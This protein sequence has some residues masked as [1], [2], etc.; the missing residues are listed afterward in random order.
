MSRLCR[1]LIHKAVSHSL[2]II[3]PNRL[4]VIHPAWT[5][6]DAFENGILNWYPIYQLY[7][8]SIY[9]KYGW[10]VVSCFLLVTEP[11][12]GLQFVRAHLRHVK[13]TPW[14][15]SQWPSSSA[16]WSIPWCVVKHELRTSSWAIK[17]GWSGKMRPLDRSC[18]WGPFLIVGGTRLRNPQPPAEIL[19][20]KPLSLSRPFVASSYQ[21]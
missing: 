7:S 11:V 10:Y 20:S 18:T 2:G 16:S 8:A 1:C 6:L 5:W 21:I 15:M 12:I 3:Y 13:K 17:S 9:L 4:S 14:S 19:R